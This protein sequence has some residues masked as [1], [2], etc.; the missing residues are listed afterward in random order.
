MN[1]INIFTISLSML[2]LII[3]WFSM[4]NTNK[5]HREDIKFR[6]EQE[7]YKRLKPY[8]N[9]LHNTLKDFDDIFSQYTKIANKFYSD[10][11]HLI[12]LYSKDNTTIRYYLGEASDEI[13]NEINKDILFQ[14]EVYLFRNKLNFFRKINYKLDIKTKKELTSFEHNLKRLYENI[15]SNKK[16]EYLSEFTNNM[17]NVHNIYSNNQDKFD[18]TI[19]ELENIFNIYKKYTENDE[20][21]NFS[22]KFQSLIHLLNYIKTVSTDYTNIPDKNFDELILSEIIYKLVSTQIII[23]SI[24]KIRFM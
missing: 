15:D 14:N 1:T 20:V 3:A 24:N 12:D 18:T 5:W 6:R 9:K 17:Q 10:M 11:Y 16:H 7:N 2:S 23:N 13:L 8:I 4:Y 22:I 21:F 19:K